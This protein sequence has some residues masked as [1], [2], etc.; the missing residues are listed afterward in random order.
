VGLAPANTRLRYLLGSALRVGGAL[1]EA[2]SVLHS[3]LADDPTYSR[4]WTRLGAVYV[5]KGEPAAATAALRRAIEIDPRN[6]EA[7]FELARVA[8]RAGDLAEA[9]RLLGVIQGL[10]QALGRGPRRDY[11]DRLLAPKER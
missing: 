7:Y 2:E 6:V 1:D 5:A 4:A 3:V 10:E 8:V 9:H 11:S